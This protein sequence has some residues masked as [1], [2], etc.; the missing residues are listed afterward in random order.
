[1]AIPIILERAAPLGEP[2]AYPP[3]V[4][5]FYGINITRRRVRTGRIQVTNEF[6][7]SASK[8]ITIGQKATTRHYAGWWTAE[9]TLFQLLNPLEELDKIVAEGWSVRC[10][11]DVTNSEW[12][13]LN[14]EK[15]EDHP[16]GVGSLRIDFSITL[17]KK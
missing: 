2:G 11:D 15:D 4:L 5:G 14:Y 16:Y 12:E 8:T 13:I 10:N 6:Y 9:D 1:M 3:I 7:K 17:V